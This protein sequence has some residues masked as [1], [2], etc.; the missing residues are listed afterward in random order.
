MLIRPTAR[1]EYLGVSIIEL[2]RKSELRTALYFVL[3]TPAI[4]NFT[5]VTQPLLPLSIAFNEA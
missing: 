3:A 1:D 2:L 4:V 5:S